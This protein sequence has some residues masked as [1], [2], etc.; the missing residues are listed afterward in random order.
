MRPDLL[1]PDGLPLLASGNAFK[2]G[3][4]AG[5]WTLL[6]GAGGNDKGR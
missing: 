4:L 1:G 6:G 2:A 3:P 5:Q